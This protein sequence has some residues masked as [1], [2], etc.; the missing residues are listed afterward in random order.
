MTPPNSTFLV[1]VLSPHFT[2]FLLS[3]TLSISLYKHS[4]LSTLVGDLAEERQTLWDSLE[5][6]RS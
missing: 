5:K 4:Y 3:F 2:Q 6:H 1:P